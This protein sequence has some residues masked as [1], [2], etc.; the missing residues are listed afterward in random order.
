[1]VWLISFNTTLRWILTA[2]RCSCSAADAQT[3]SKQS[4][5]KETDSVFY[6]SLGGVKGIGTKLL[7]LLSTALMHNLKY[8]LEKVLYFMTIL[9]FLNYSKSKSILNTSIFTCLPSKYP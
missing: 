2:I 3:G 8:K 5:M 7:Q 1:M 4:T 6:T 9:Q